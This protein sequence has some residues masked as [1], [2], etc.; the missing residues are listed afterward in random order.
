MLYME[1]IGQTKINVQNEQAQ[2]QKVHIISLFLVIFGMKQIDVFK[3][4]L[5]LQCRTNSFPLNVSYFTVGL[6]SRMPHVAAD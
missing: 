6:N 1:T 3:E 5:W 2:Q 4:I